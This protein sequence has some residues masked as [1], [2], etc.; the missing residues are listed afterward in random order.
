MI[1]WKHPVCLQPP[2]LMGWYF[3]RVAIMAENKNSFILYTDL[4]HTV[5][6]LTNEKAGKLFKHIL[7]YV[8]DKNP[9]TDDI[10]IIIAFE[11]IKQ[12]LKRDLRKYEQ[13]RETNRENALKRWHPD[14]ATA[15]N[16]IQT[17]A[18]HAVSVSVSDSVN[19]IVSD[20]N[21]INI[22]FDIFWNK[23]NNKIGDKGTACD[24]WE[25]KKKLKDGTK[26]NGADRA[27]IIESIPVM[28]EYYKQKE[29]NLPHATTMLY[30][31]RWEN[32]FQIEKTKKVSDYGN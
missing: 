25:G 18:K 29:Y 17:D 14:N 23:Y 12:S 2:D 24:Y 11:P 5:E 19:D 30:Q 21:K 6:K 31:R 7:N 20:I 27:N 32:E 4:I 15:C 8:N 3:L 16:R 22:E 10:I 9:Q 13:K 28:K 1:I 26:I